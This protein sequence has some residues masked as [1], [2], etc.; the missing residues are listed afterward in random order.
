[1]SVV[2][3]IMIIFAVHCFTGMDAVPNMKRRC[4]IWKSGFSILHKKRCVCQWN[5]R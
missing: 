2:Q 4:A 3:S 1:M 5:I